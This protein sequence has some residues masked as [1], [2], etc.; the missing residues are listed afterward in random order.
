MN[1]SGG[2]SGVVH[3]HARPPAAGHPMAE[4]AHAAAE[5]WLTAAIP[6]ENPW[7]SCKLTRVRIEGGGGC[8]H[9]RLRSRSQRG[10]V[11]GG[12]RGRLTGGRRRKTKTL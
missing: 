1:D 3:V 12:G 10:A 7:C 5:S 9:E 11:G 6:V 4:Y 2:G 8:T